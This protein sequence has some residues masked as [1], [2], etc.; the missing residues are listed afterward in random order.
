[1][2][3]PSIFAPPITEL[4][5]SGIEVAASPSGGKG[6]ALDALGKAPF[7][8]LPVK[9]GH[10]TLTWQGGG[11][12]FSNGITVTH[13][14]EHQPSFATAIADQSGT[15]QFVAFMLQALN[16]VTVQFQAISIFPAAPAVTDTTGF[17]WFVI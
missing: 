11:S 16:P 9:V 1:M 10:A 5:K 13:N 15:V 8:A 6:L 4:A 3:D 7:G 14:L 2:A 12:Q 17:F